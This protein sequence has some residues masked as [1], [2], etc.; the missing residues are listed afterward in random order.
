ADRVVATDRVLVSTVVKHLDVD[1]TRVSVVPNAVDLETIDRLTDAA[2]VHGIRDR[3]GLSA[4]DLL[5][6]GVGRLEENKGFQHLV[7]AIARYAARQSSA[8]AGPPQKWRCVI[9]GEGSARA[10]LER[11]IASA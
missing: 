2:A 7:A 6:V 11:D 3:L 5:F 8:M 9:L 4:N 1:Q 10:P